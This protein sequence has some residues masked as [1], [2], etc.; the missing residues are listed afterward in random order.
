MWTWLLIDWSFFMKICLRI[1]IFV[2]SSSS[3]TS[4]NWVKKIS[5]KWVKNESKMPESKKHLKLNHLRVF[6]KSNPSQNNTTWLI[7]WAVVQKKL[8]GSIRILS[9]LKVKCICHQVL[10]TSFDDFLRFLK[11]PCECWAENQKLSFGQIFR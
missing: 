6:E 10:L 11:V 5:I 1:L 3:K 4:Q 7:F 8:N 9:H 2:K